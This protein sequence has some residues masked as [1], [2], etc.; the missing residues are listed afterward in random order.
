MKL[1]PILIIA[2]LI[3]LL[4]G[5]VSSL[6]NVYEVRTGDSLSKIATQFGTSVKQIT[7]INGLK[8]TLIYPGQK[9]RV[10]SPLK[11]IVAP[12][13]PYYWR[14][15]RSPLQKSPGYL[16]SPRQS[17]LKD[18]QD[19]HRL[20]QAYHADLNDRFKKVKNRP[21]PLEGW[22]IVLDP[23]HG[24]RDPGAIV[25]NKD[26]RNREVHVVEDEYVY[27]MAMRVMERLVLYGA[28]VGMTVLSPN[29]L[30]RDNVPADQTFVNEQNEVYNDEAYNRK[31][32][33][34][35]RP[36]SHNIQRRAMIANRFHKGAKRGRSLFLSLHA[37]NSPS[38]PK[39]PLVIYQKK[40][41]RI[42]KAS[43]RFAEFVQRAL[44]HPS[45][46]SQIGTRN[47]AVLRDNRSRAEILI[48]IRN[49]S[50]IDDAWALRFYGKRQEDAD[51]IVKGVLDYVKRSG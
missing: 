29:H 19:G 20:L 33:P 24:G 21:T 13:G 25:S 46:A 50:V 51:R 39:G 34:L 6:T 23:G 3:C 5:T 11:E 38:R 47:M 2:P 14:Q 26:G 17:A 1:P 10:G 41:S 42:D 45:V 22:R 28:D 44:D 35:V 49:V 43:K 40:G 31:K 30:T 18:Y 12:N 36:G 32:D 16:E 15:P 37:D 27:D 7:R 4:C 9:L 48:E 8:S